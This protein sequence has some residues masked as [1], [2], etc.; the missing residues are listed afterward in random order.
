[1]WHKS[2]PNISRTK[3]LFIIID[4]YFDSYSIDQEYEK[5]LISMK[6]TRVGKKIEL[7]TEV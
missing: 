5:Y 1:M 4:K 3:H 6:Q 2:K 7:S